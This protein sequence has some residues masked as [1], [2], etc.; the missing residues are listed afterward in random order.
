MSIRP[1]EITSPDSQIAQEVLE[2]T[3]MVFQDVCENAMQAYI[4]YKAYYDKKTNASKKL[5][6]ADY[7]YILQPKSDH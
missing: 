7:V 1:Q 2:Q 4:K 5:K 6:Q 3:E